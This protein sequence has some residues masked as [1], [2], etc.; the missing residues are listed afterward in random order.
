MTTTLSSNYEQFKKQNSYSSGGGT[1][2]YDQFVSEMNQAGIKTT[3][4]NNGEANFADY[5]NA[6]SDDLKAQIMDSYDCAQ[7]Y[8]LQSLI[9]GVYSDSGR[10]VLQSGE[11]INACKSLG[12][13]VNVQYQETSYIPDWKAGNFS[14]SI[15]EG[16]AIAV[17]TISDGMG[18]EIVVAD[19][20]G[21]AAL[22]SEELFM[23]QILGDI[24]YEISAT[25]GVG[26]T[27]Y[28]SGSGSSAVSASEES[29]SLFGKEEEKDKEAKQEEYNTLVEKFLNNGS[30]MEDAIRK[31]DTQLHVDNLTYSGSMEEKTEANV[32]ETAKE[33]VEKETKNEEVIDEAVDK[34]IKQ[35]DKSDDVETIADYTADITKEIIEEAN[36]FAA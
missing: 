23:N 12:L 14:N 15:R 10:S 2:S 21:N 22:E 9:A 32:E 6:L 35:K 1:K 31:A 29:N 36:F 13:S 18:G 4:I 5:G 30:S 33:T 34:T 16:G 8:E 24:N 20:N 17:Y 28:S 19:A 25:K 27:I 7:D 11:F 3:H 26:A